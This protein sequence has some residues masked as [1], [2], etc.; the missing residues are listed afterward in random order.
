[1]KVNSDDF[2]FILQTL[3]RIDNKAEVEFHGNAWRDGDVDYKSLDSI[4]IVFAKE[5][6]EDT[7]LI[8]SIS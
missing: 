1:M 3:N 6:N 5:K 4:S 2:K 8:I 7:K